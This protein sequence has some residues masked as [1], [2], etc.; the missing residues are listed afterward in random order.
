ME[1]SQLRAIVF[2][3]LRGADNV[4]VGVGPPVIGAGGPGGVW[5]ISSGTGGGGGGAV[6]YPRSTS[7]IAE[8]VEDIVSWARSQTARMEG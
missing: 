3:I 1:N 5:P 6:A 4:R 8:Q 2:A 7:E